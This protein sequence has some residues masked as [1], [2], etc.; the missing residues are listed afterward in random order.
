M[1]V[2]NITLVIFS[3]RVIVQIMSYKDI[4]NFALRGQLRYNKMF[5]EP[6][7]KKVLNSEFLALLR[8]LS[9]TSFIQL[10]LQVSDSFLL[11]HM[12]W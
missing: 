12:F 9:E 4:G 8:M 2:K 10:I 3:L 1:I 6:E 11:H 7:Y 5:C